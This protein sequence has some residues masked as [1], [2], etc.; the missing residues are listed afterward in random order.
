[1]KGKL[2]NKH[3]KKF[4]NIQFKN[5]VE[6]YTAINNIDTIYC[7][8][9]QL[10]VSKAAVRK[11]SNDEQF[12]ARRRSDSFFLVSVFDDTEILIRFCR[13]DI[14]NLNGNNF[15]SDK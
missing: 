7:W 13:L 15:K 11:L 9:D 12:T 3:T 10:R 8:F 6:L 5:I 2:F 14:K 1:M 4:K